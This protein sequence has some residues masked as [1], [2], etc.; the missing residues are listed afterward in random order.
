MFE[1]LFEEGDC[2]EACGEMFGFSN[3]RA[4][5]DIGPFK[6][7]EIIPCIWFFTD[8]G[9]LSIT[10][11]VG[12]EIWRGRALLNLETEPTVIERQF[13]GQDHHL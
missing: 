3:S 4:K 6:A 9:A 7:G 8:T 5:V 10:N 2:Q 11:D 1:L 13:L 12:E